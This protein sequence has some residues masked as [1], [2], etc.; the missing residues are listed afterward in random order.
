L[1]KKSK[2]SHC[3]KYI[4]ICFSLFITLSCHGQVN[5]SINLKK[6]ATGF[7]SPVG[8]ACPDDGTGR[9][10]IFEQSGKV[11]IY[12]NGVIVKTPFINISERLD[13]LNVAY[14]EKG[15]LG[16]AFHPQYKSNGRFFLYYSAPHSQ[17][18]FDHKSVIAEFR[19]SPENPDKAIDKP[20]IIMEFLQPESNHNG[21]MLE[22]GPD[23]FLYIGS[24]DGGGANDEHGTIGNGQDKG[25]L[26]GKIL[27]IDVDSR[28]PYGI[29]PDNPFVNQSGS[30]AEI[31]AYGLRNPWRFSFDRET[32]RLF[33]G[34]VGQN[35]YEEV[36]IIKKGGNYGWR[37]MEGYHCFK[38]S[39]NCN[40][41]GLELPIDEYGREKG[42]S[43][44]GGYVYGGN[45]INAIKGMYVFG[46]WS[47]KL[48]L[49]R[50]KSNGT[51]ERLEPNI[52]GTGKNELEGK[53]NSMGQDRNGHIYLLTQKL[54]GPKSPTG[55]L[56]RITK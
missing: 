5:P 13:G 16:M 27:R 7:T 49:L 30:R 39:V 33:C 48:Y 46:D 4:L 35:K 28:K 15:L 26:L 17:K 10:F 52:N 34:D 22:F 1:K 12:K 24:G 56:Y 20:E 36:N 55:V 21:G 40:K 3:L 19:V 29:P 6:L 53:L 47:G 41:S 43:I 8:M 51:W 44:C 37:I 2:M 9:L 25:N 18:G 31:F 54:F 23:G 50:Q 45:E 38:P 42:I 11:I 32:G 14:S